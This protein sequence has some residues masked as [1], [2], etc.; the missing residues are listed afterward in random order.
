MCVGGNEYVVCVCVWGGC[1]CVCGGCVFEG[2]Y[3]YVQGDVYIC[4]RE[5]M[6]VCMRECVC[7]CVC[8]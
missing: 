2:M 3:M 6:C 8:V 7:V 4:M 5:S 1:V